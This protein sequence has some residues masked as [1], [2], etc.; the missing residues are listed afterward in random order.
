MLSAL[1]IYSYFPKKPSINT[2][3]KIID[4]NR[5]IA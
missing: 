5:L 4:E 1:I 3:N 2:I